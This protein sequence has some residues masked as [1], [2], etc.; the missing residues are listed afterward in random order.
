MKRLGR[1]EDL[2]GFGPIALDTYMQN[3]DQNLNVTNMDP[4]V[5]CN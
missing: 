4:V 2:S 5:A 1:N 3:I